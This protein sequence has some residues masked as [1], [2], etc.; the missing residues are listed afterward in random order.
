MLK[1]RILKIAFVLTCILTLVMPYTTEV[2]AAI[3]ASQTVVTMAAMR[4]YEGDA[5]HNPISY[6]ANGD[7]VF[8][9]MAKENEQFTYDNVFYCLDANKSFPG[10]I[11]G[12]GEQNYNKVSENFED[13]TD[14]NVKSLKMTVPPSEQT[15]WV[16]NYQAVV[17]LVNNLYSSKIN[18]A[19]RDA[20]L[21]KAFAGSEYDIDAVKEIISESDIDATQQLAIW[22]FTNGDDDRFSTNQI[23][24]ITVSEDGA[25][26]NGFDSLGDT[27]VDRQKNIL[28]GEY[29]EHLYKYLVD[30]AEHAMDEAALAYPT[31]DTEV[32]G[33]VPKATGYVGVGPFKINGGTVSKSEYTI[34]LVDQNNQPITNYQIAIE[35][36]SEFTNKKVDEIFDKAFYV[37]LPKDTEVTNVKLSLKYSRYETS[38]SLWENP[39][40]QNGSELVYQPIVLITREEVPYDQAKEYEVIKVNE[41]PDLALRKYIVKVNNV[42]E[43]RKP[44]VVSVGLKDGEK[45]A[46]Y[47]H[48]KNPVEVGVGDRVVYEIRVYNEGTVPGA[49][50]VIYDALPVGLELV[51]DSEINN[52]YGWEKVAN[53]ENRVVYKTTA[54]AD[55][56][57]AAYD[58]DT[59]TLSS[60]HVQIEVVVKDLKSGTGL[61]NI[62][63][64]ATDDIDD[65]DS[66]TGDHSYIRN[67]QDATN[68]IG[69]RDNEGKDL[70]DKNEYFKGVE[71][72][73]DF[74]KIIVK[75]RPFDLALRKF[76]SKVN[77]VVPATSREPVVDVAPLKAGKT[78][79]EYSTVKTPLTVRKGD[80]VT[81]TLRVYNEG[82]E[83]GYAEEVADFLPEGL[84]FL[85]DYKGNIDNYWK[86]PED[87]KTVKL[88]TIENGKEHL[89]L[90]DFQDVTS[91]DDVDVILG[92]AKLTSTKLKSNDV[93]EKNLI[94]AFDKTNGKELKYKDIEV[95]CIVIADELTNNNFRNIAEIIHESNEDKVPQDENDIDSTPGTVNPSN[96]PGADEEQDD[97]DY[98]NLTPAAVPE[99]DLSLQKYISQ[100]NNKTVSDRVPTITKN[101]DGK[102]RFNHSTEP[103]AVNYGDVVVFTLRVYNEGDIDGY[104]KEITDYLPTAGLEFDKDNEINK[105]YGWKLY[106]NNDKETS[107]VS[108]AVKAKTDY[109][110]KEVS[111]KRNEDCLIKAFDPSKDISATNPDF[112]YVQIAF[113][114][115]A[116]LS[117]GA[118]A[119]DRTYK[120]VA[121]IS[122]DEDKD[123]NPVE[124]RDSTPGN[125]KDGEDDIDNDKISVRY[126]DLSLDKKLVK[127]VVT[128]DGKTTEIDVSNTDALQKVEIHRKKIDST[129]VKFVYTITVKNEG[130]IEGYATEIKDYIPEGLTFVKE[131]NPNWTSSGDKTIT[132]NALANT[133]IKPGQTASTQVTLR[134]VNGENNFGIKTNVA[135]ISADKNESGT[136][137]IDSTPNNQKSGEDDIDEAPV[138]L[139]ISTGITSPKYLALTGTVLAIWGIGIA[140]IKRYVLD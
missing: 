62:A 42:V 45:T 21:E 65:D 80:I 135:E 51:E 88:S 19:Q 75:G 103:L 70:T 7:V 84:G 23:P 138:M 54:L 114:V 26:Y 43:D 128:A 73:D 11:T 118:T 78:D 17:W 14:V 93:D 61:T 22:H 134:W 34:A 82:E 55:K 15:E 40:L 122:D 39:R 89:V 133:L 96:Y 105:K 108:Q 49:A 119:N 72:D 104:A 44:T 92:T 8:K 69:D 63:E 112:E 60:D 30:N 98:E 53:G 117:S 5:N 111:E 24:A 110:S 127:I 18:A 9:L 130:E 1:R 68:Y 35:G 67:D 13:P 121:E 20:Y 97:N 74:E 85:K 140:L 6:R 66:H 25:T 33:E 79:A 109:L 77:G 32:T 48:A 136:P 27:E 52:T 56:P 50:T 90:T 123:G 137:D 47:K 10:E 101:S 58:P 116:T 64:I 31:L 37:F 125:K 129:V 131:D 107:T 139:A 126:F 100:V 132:T 115:T 91:L 36:E 113:K 99:F 38:A 86:I 46:V 2:L 94:G 106:D 102:L 83:A 57:I 81:Y 41:R 29:M 95:T 3:P 71:D 16:A 87:S 4:M 76:I 12:E 59:D 120:N 28:R 124:D